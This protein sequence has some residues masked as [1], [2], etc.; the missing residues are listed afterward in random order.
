MVAPGPGA[1]GTEAWARSAF[2]LLGGLPAVRRVGLAIVEAG[3]RQLSFAAS[4]R[5]T[6]ELWCHVDAYEDVPLNNTVRTGRLILGSPEEL[7]G[8]YPVFIARQAST[9]RAL[10]TVPLVAAAQVMG[11]FALFYGVEQPFD[12]EQVGELRRMGESLGADLR[13]GQRSVALP[14]RPLADAAVPTGSRV[15]SHL[16]PPDPEGVPAAR[17]FTRDTL[18]A[19]DV[20][21][22]TQET[23][24]LCISELV[25][26]AII[27]T[28]AGCEVRL[29]LHRG[30]LTAGVRD[31]GTARSRPGSPPDDPLAV[32]GRGLHLVDVLSSRWGSQLDTAGMTV[33]C[34]FVTRVA[35]LDRG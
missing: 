23:A 13:R 18:R 32:H 25:T 3:G 35:D 7:E 27:H 22:D 1:A 14:S 34:E 30:I 28:T 19:W 5:D 24:V 21:V 9:T 26:N 10:A 4:D 29:E 6:G 31:G 16:F 20:D 11:G 15:A 12:A 17:R 8:R 33:W 2:E